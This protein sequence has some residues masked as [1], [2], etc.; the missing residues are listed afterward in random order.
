MAGQGMIYTRDQAKK[1]LLESNRDYQNKLT[2]QNLFSQNDVTAA[3]AQQQLVNEYDTASA[4]AYV[5][6][7]Q[8]Q[9]A[10]RNSNVVGAGKQ[11][12]YDENTAALNE[13]YATYKQQLN[14]GQTS[15]E[16]ARLERQQ[17]INDL[18]EYQAE[19]TSKYTNAHLDY[20]NTLWEKYQAGENQLFDQGT[21]WN[22]YVKYDP[23]LD[24]QGQQ[25][26]DEEGNVIL[27][28]DNPHLM[29]TQE[30]A[31][32]L[33]DADNNLTIKGVDFF[34]Q[35]ENQLANQGGYSWGD[36]LA[37]T[38]EELF[39]WAREYNPYNYTGDGTNAGTLR[40]MYGMASTDQTYTFAERY[41]GLTEKELDTMLNDFTSSLGNITM[42]NASE[43]TDKIMNMANKFGIDEDLAAAGL[44][45]DTLN[46]MVDDIKA[47]YEAAKSDSAGDATKSTVAGAVGGAIIGGGTTA[48]VGAAI[49]ASLGSAVPGIGT[50]IGAL[51]G[52]GIGAIAGIGSG[53]VSNKVNKD[54]YNKQLQTEYNKLVAE[55]TNYLR[56][57][58]RESQINF[59]I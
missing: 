38:D 32:M 56:A 2:W 42:D 30:I 10:I 17:Q 18:L 50:A 48:T 46:Q 28:V 7:L 47:Q 33:Y 13:A 54:K 27:D 1:Q 21:Q 35:L 53:H 36:Y 58:R 6:Y 8:N 57:K 23:L 20:L 9:N 14:E 55:M 39:D 15:I 3:K 45:R 19:M 43:I 16:N 26:L 52:A 49:G 51:L 25:Q 34:D 24:E 22:K 40:T 41:A 59:N 11:Q 5:S 37:E 12:L 29:S 31:N 44:D 4:D